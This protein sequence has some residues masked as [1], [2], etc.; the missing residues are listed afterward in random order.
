MAGKR[1]IPDVRGRE[2]F[3]MSRDRAK[4]KNIYLISYKF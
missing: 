1:V 2:I 4:K 3:G